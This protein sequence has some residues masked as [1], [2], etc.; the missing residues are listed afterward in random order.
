MLPEESIEYRQEASA[1]SHQES[2]CGVSDP[3]SMASILFRKPSLYVTSQFNCLLNKSQL[4][5]RNCSSFLFPLIQRLAFSTVHWLS[6]LVAFALWWY[7]Q[8]YTSGSICLSANQCSSLIGIYSYSQSHGFWLHQ[9]ISF[10]F[11]RYSALPT[12]CNYLVLLLARHFSVVIRILSVTPD[13]L[14]FYRICSLLNFPVSPRH[15]MSICHE[16]DIL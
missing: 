7:R 13:I 3:T 14:A 12:I 2:T 8:T 9:Y 6:A 16:L 11:L 1:R 10:V 5:T 15:T 4:S